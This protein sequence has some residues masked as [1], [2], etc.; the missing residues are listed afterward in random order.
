MFERVNDARSFGSLEYC[1]WSVGQYELR[2]SDRLP[3]HPAV[4][5]SERGGFFDLTEA[6]RGTLKSF[7][8]PGAPV[9][10]VSQN[11]RAGWR[12]ED[13]RLAVDKLVPCRGKPS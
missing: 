13:G 6:L 3:R 11:H 1:A 9:L 8:Q 12:G 4:L 10:S 5:G 7:P 2:S